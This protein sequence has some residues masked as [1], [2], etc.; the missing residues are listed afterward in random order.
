[1]V[2]SYLALAGIAVC[3]W[4]PILIRFY[5]N[6][7]RRQNPISLAICSA[8]TLLMWLAV[9]GIW[10]VSGDVRAEVVSFVST[11]VSIV[12]AGYANFTFYLAAKKFDD[13]EE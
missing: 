2:A 1:M 7:K 10:E 3:A 11:G 4:A 9:A 8:I 13:R 5:R 12:V 6:W